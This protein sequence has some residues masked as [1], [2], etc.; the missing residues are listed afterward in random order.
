MPAVKTVRKAIIGITLCTVCLRA[1]GLLHAI[2]RVALHTGRHTAPR[3]EKVRATFGGS[4]RTIV[5]PGNVAAKR[6]W[7]AFRLAA[8]PLTSAAACGGLWQSLPIVPLVT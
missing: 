3:N 5:P 1:K 4:A 7:R 6:D 2:H 8:T